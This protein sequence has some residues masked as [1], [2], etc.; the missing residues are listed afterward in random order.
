MTDPPETRSG[1]RTKCSNSPSMTCI[2]CE[3]FY[4]REYCTYE[5]KPGEE[6]VSALIEEL[7]VDPELA[8]PRMGRAVDVVEL[9]D[10]V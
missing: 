10:A 4:T 7:N 9:H 8:P 3:N 6:N 5:R 2:S 1:W